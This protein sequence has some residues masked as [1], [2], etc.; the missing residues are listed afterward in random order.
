MTAEWIGLG[1]CDLVTIK[2]RES[3]HEV[4]LPC[5]P[6]I[7]PPSHRFVQNIVGFPQILITTHVPTSGASNEFFYTEIISENTQPQ[8]Q[9]CWESD[10]AHLSQLHA[11]KQDSIF[12]EEKKTIVPTSVVRSWGRNDAHAV[13]FF[14]TDAQLETSFHC[15]FCNTTFLG[16][17]FFAAITFPLTAGASV[18]EPDLKTTPNP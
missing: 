10:V 18:L 12:T 3:T 14:F 7:P 13:Y 17:W 5:R 6:H 2:I 15:R 1:L 8:K 16:L 11:M 4:W 9:N